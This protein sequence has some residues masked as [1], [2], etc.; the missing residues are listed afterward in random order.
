MTPVNTGFLFSAFSTIP[1]KWVVAGTT[2]NVSHNFN[3][4]Q[5]RKGSQWFELHCCLAVEIVSDQKYYPI[6]REFCEPPCY[7]DEHYIPTLVNILAAEEN[8]NRSITWVDWSKHGRHPVKFGRGDTS[9][10]FVNRMRLGGNCSYN[11]NRTTS[12]CFPFGRKFVPSTLQPL[13]RMVPLLFGS[14][15]QSLP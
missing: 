6:F 12:V 15:Q 9:E 4:D 7:M 11:G 1:G 10:E 3:L 14:G 2:Q 13:L 8:L 5:W